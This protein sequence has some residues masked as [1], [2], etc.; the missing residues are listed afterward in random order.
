M[1]EWEANLPPIMREK[2]ARIGE[3]TPGEKERMKDLDEMTSLLSRFYKG[4]LSAEGLWREL[5]D[6]KDKGK[7]YLLKEAQVKLI[8]S[9]S[10]GSAEAEFQKRRD[11][12]LATESLKEHRNTATLEQNLNS[13]KGLQTKYRDEMEKAY[14]NLKAQVE[15]NPQLRMHQVKQGQATVVAQL[16][17]DEAV[18]ISPEWKR[19]VASHEKRYG[20]EFARA[21]ERLRQE[22]K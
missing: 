2:L 16:T 12:V 22:A 10:L 14:S 9:L 13:I 3:V 19:F 18:K 5:K 17:V 20:Q 7:G 1:S 8:D 6:Y 4:E 21:M 11:G 15:R